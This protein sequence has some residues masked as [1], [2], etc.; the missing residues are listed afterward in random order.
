MEYL[1]TK[2]LAAALSIFVILCLVGTIFYAFGD[3]LSPNKQVTLVPDK[4]LYANAFDREIDLSE[5]RTDEE[6]IELAC[7][8]YDTANLS[9]KNCDRCAYFVTSLTETMS[10]PVYGY[11]HLLKTGNEYYYTEYSAPGDIGFL[12]K[13]M[14]PV[15]TDF[16]LRKYTN[17]EMTYTYAERALHPTLT[18][19]EEK[20]IILEAETDWTSLVSGYPQEEAQAV[21]H[22]SQA[23][24]YYQTDLII[25]TD[26]VLSANIFYDEEEGYY[27]IELELDAANPKT[28]EK[29]I[30]NVRA[31]SS[32]MKNAKYTSIV[33]TIEIWDN[34]CFRY[35]DSVE[36]IQGGVALNIDFVTYFHY[37]EEYL[38]P[39]AY[40][41]FI[42]IK[43]IALS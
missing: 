8:M 25:D 13:M 21:F 20:T 40:S 23:D 28:S 11:R 24:D 35:F 4:P 19:D 39:E 7:Y 37:D 16:S 2:K 5:E 33:E 43:E 18:I 32:L 12:K 9:F 42:E 22:P 15:T 30:A 36:K 6:W 3:S 41:D 29:T 31:G 26:T 27:T 14:D 17:T 38:Q 34:G 10:L 1:N